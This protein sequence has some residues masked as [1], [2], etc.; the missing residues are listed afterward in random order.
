MDTSQYSWLYLQSLAAIA[1]KE[2]EMLSVVKNLV[3]F[4][5][6]NAPLSFSL[7]AEGGDGRF[8][9]RDVWFYRP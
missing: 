1:T 5:T 4:F 9:G 2:V 8:N 3:I 6:P 7:L